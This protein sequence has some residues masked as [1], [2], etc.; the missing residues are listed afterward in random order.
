MQPPHLLLFA[1]YLLSDANRTS[2]LRW[3]DFWQICHAR[4]L[5]R[6]DRALTDDGLTFHDLISDD[7]DR[8]L[9]PWTAKTS[10]DHFNHLGGLGRRSVT[11]SYSNSSSFV[12]WSR[13]CSLG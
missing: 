3:P 12:S 11:T 7:A 4:P 2:K 5:R 9:A 6:A 1:K 8:E 13:Y 10:Q